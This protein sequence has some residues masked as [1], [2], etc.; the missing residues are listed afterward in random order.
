MNVNDAKLL[1][2]ETALIKTG[3]VDDLESEWL[4]SQL[5]AY[6]GPTLINDLWQA[7]WD[8]V[9][10]PAVIPAGDNSDRAYFWLGGLGYIGS[11]SDR[12]SQYWHA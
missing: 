8:T 2:L 6:T 1:K 4:L 5:V 11:L 9:T 7:Y 10:V 12:W 3:S